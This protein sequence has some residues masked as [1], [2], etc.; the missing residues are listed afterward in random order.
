MILS[1]V[2][3]EI[4]P[5][6]GSSRLDVARANPEL[7]LQV[8][9]R[10]CHQDGMDISS[11]HW[12]PGCIDKPLLLKGHRY[13]RCLFSE[14]PR[15]G[16]RL[17]KT[18]THPHRQW[19]SE[20]LSLAVLSRAPSLVRAEF[21]AINTLQFVGDSASSSRAGPADVIDRASDGQLWWGQ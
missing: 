8:R 14:S 20:P 18:Q 16:L 9:W 15:E 19:W 4:R 12:F 7:L 11:W 10:W 6:M 5:E 21:S 2:L 17:R 1:S 3:G 13:Q